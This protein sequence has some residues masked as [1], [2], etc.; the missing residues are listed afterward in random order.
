[1][2]GKTV[3]RTDQIDMMEIV[4]QAIELNADYANSYS[5]QYKL[6]SPVGVYKVIGDRDRLMQVMANLMSNAAKF[7]PAGSVVEIRILAQK[8][9]VRIEVEDHGP[10]I[11]DEFRHRIFSEFAQADSSDTRQQGGTVL[12]L[13]ISQKLVAR[14]DGEIGY[15]TEVGKGSIFWFA[16]PY[17][18]N[19]G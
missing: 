16:L 9:M 15:E 18:P 13:N 17:A 3:F 7:S 14:M 10:G 1:M 19:Q 4:Q 8:T 6:C 5:V 2:S 12:G 11:P